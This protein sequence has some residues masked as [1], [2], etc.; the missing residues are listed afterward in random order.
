MSIDLQSLINEVLG[1]VR[2]G[3]KNRAATAGNN[4]YGGN[5]D[6]EDYWKDI[7]QRNTA[8]EHQGVGESGRTSRTKRHGSG[9]LGSA[10]VNG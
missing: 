9:S 10:E 5:K 2:E 4:W 7:R 8:L 1:M 6:E 3:Q